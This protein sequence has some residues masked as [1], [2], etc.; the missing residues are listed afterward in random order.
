MSITIH[1]FSLLYLFLVGNVEHASRVQWGDSPL[2]GCPRNHPFFPPSFSGE[3]ACQGIDSSF[4]AVY[5]AIMAEESST[6]PA[7]LKSRI[8]PLP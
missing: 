3:C 2:A 4:G 5:A 1:F 7:R 8:L 6:R